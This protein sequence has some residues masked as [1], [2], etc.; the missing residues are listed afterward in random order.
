MRLFT[1][2]QCQPCQLLKG[3]IKES[4]VEGITV[5]D[6]QSENGGKEA[7]DLGI[8]SVPTLVTDEATFTGID[9]IIKELGI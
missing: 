3:M 2:M 7:E 9:D 6:A 5:V 4:K 1:T 8:R